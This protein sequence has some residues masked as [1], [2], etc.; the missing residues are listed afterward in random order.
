VNR[1]I[2]HHLLS[3][4]S[5]IVGSAIASSLRPA[6]MNRDHL[7]IRGI[8]FHLDA[9]TDLQFTVRRR[10]PVS[11]D[12]SCITPH[13]EA[14]GLAVGHADQKVAMA[15]FDGQHTFYG[16]IAFQKNFL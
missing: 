13:V 12:L 6:G 1:L 5:N 14:L 10:F 15:F 11:G 3:L 9:V 4:G 7:A 16:W 8:I 2:Q